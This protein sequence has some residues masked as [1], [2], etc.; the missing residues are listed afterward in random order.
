MTWSDWI[1]AVAAATLPA[2]WVTQMVKRRTMMRRF[3]DA[4]GM[5]FR[6]M[7]PSDKYEPYIQFDVVRWG[8]LL[9]NVMEGRWSGFDMCV[10]ELSNRGGKCTGAIVVLP[11]E[12]TRFRITPPTFGPWHGFTGFAHRWQSPRPDAP[13]LASDVV[14]KEQLA[15]S[16]AAGIGART[17][18][19]LRSIP[20]VFLETNM[21]LVLVLLTHRV[22]LDGVAAF[23]DL[24]ASLARALDADAAE[25][26]LSQP[27]D[28]ATV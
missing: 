14:V 1:V 13:A 16:A 27:S 11:R 22:R 12:A 15:G 17:A 4:H 3:A 28:D 6:G 10:F 18:A 7:L 5:R 23:L 9:Y 8:V 26:P 24:V 19:I 20:L 21:G 25:R 2:M